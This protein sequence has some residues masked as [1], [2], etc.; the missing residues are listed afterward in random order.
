VKHTPSKAFEIVSEFEAAIGEYTGAPS[1]VAVN[2]CTM[3][4]RLCLDWQRA[5]GIRPTVTI[6]KRTYLS[7]PMQ[8]KKAGFN[9]AFRNEDWEGYY[10]LEPFPIWD[11][12]REFTSRMFD[13]YRGEFDQ[14]AFVCASFYSGK[15]LSLKRHRL[16]ETGSHCDIEQGGAI[17]H[18]A[19]P[20]A[21]HFFRAMRHDGRIEGQSI[22][23]ESVR[24][25]G[26]HCY[27][28]PSSARLGLRLLAHLPKHN[29]PLLN[30][31]FPDLSTFEVFK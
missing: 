23:N 27:M 22:S 14:T 1:V 25:L 3:A 26:H 16:D 21:D 15:P 30:D 12:A 28:N 2:S 19:G 9:V 18:N 5:Q 7:V 10:R 4:L 6:P 24:L 8:I 11:S 17:L 13:D 31:D 29:P 20:E